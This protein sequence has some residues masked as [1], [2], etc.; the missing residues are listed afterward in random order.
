[1]RFQTDNERTGQIRG[2]WGSHRGAEGTVLSRRLPTFGRSVCLH[3][4]DCLTLQMKALHASETSVTIYHSLR[5]S[6][7]ENLKHT[8]PQGL[9]WAGSRAARVETTVS[10]IT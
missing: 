8:C 2:V 10:G 6:S 7:T 1:V 9:L 4:V 3:V 5:R